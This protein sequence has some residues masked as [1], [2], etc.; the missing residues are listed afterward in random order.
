MKKEAPPFKLFGQIDKIYVWR[1]S[2]LQKLYV[3]SSM[4]VVA[5]CL[6]AVL[7]QVVL[8]HCIK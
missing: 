6:G 4:V 5:P 8:V 7:L 3:L 2:N 1:L